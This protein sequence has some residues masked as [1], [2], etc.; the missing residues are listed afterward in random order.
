MQLDN[1]EEVYLR[2][3]RQMPGEKRMRIGAELHEMAR[4]FVKASVKRGCPSIDEQELEIKT[5][6]RMC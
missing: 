6:E 1:A 3:L 4:E 2:I 5:R